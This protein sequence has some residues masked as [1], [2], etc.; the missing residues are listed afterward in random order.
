M[1]GAVGT[2]ASMTVAKDRDPPAELG[3]PPTSRHGRTVPQPDSL[4][5][6]GTVAGSSNEDPASVHTVETRE[7]VRLWD[8]IGAYS[9]SSLAATVV[10]ISEDRT[11]P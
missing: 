3:A 4:M 10:V 8:D 7:R 9:R 5:P 2:G 11:R 1:G 6:P